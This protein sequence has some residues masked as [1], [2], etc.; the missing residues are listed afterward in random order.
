MGTYGF[1][2]QEHIKVGVIFNIDQQLTLHLTL[3]DGKKLIT[4]MVYTI[5][6]WKMVNS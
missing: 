1:F 5:S 3:E 4:T 6:L 2:F